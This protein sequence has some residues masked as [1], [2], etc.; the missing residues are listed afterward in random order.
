VQLVDNNHHTVVPEPGTL[1]VLGT[2]LVGLAVLRPK[3]KG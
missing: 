3:A 2:G 1:G